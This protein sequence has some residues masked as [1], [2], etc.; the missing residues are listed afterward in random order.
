MSVEERKLFAIQR[1]LK[2]LCFEVG[3][4][5]QAKGTNKVGVI[6]Y[7]SKEPTEC[8]WKGESPLFICVGY[9]EDA[10]WHH[11]KSLKKVKS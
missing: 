3:D 2:H 5:V 10:L 9:E 11:P 1:Q 8:A 6:V 4:T 7:I